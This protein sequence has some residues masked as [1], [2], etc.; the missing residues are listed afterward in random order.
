M[1]R[2]GQTS[3][4]PF[5]SCVPLS[6]LLHLH[7]PGLPSVKREYK[8]A[9]RGARRR[10][11]TGW[12]VEPCQVIAMLTLYMPVPCSPGPPQLSGRNSNFGSS[13]EQQTRLTPCSFTWSSPQ[14]C[15]VR[16]TGLA[17][18]LVHTEEHPKERGDETPYLRPHSL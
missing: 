15:E 11:H 2:E 7:T 9:F 3:H 8:P 16:G 4:S 6:T 18:P 13:E 1:G 17:S 5:I 10:E 14:T 12:G